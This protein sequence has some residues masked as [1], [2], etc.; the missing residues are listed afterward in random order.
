MKKMT[1]E[2]TLI[3]TCEEK[4]WN[5]FLTCEKKLEKLKCVGIF[6]GQRQ[7]SIWWYEKVTTWNCLVAHHIYKSCKNPTYTNF[8][9][10]LLELIDVIWNCGLQ[11][12]LE[13]EQILV[14][15][16][17]GR[18]G[19]WVIFW[20][21]YDF[22]WKIPKRILTIWLSLDI[23]KDDCKDNYLISKPNYFH[24]III[25]LFFPTYQHGY[26]KTN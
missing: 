18:I 5:Q 23:F 26:D 10:S 13:W 16:F 22:M 12:L 7:F 25:P 8:N 15:I 20:N 4:N 1:H 11:Q 19:I 21:L 6:G 14:T 9:I 2:K 24:F 17:F 3:W